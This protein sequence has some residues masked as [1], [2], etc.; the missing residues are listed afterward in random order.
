MDR[1]KTPAENFREW[2]DGLSNF[3]AE[4]LRLPSLLENRLEGYAYLFRLVLPLI[5]AKEKRVFTG[6][7]VA[8]LI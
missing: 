5:D 7:I 6:F 3:I 1:E 4:D 8:E 2:L